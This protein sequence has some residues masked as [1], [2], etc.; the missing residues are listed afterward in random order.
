MTTLL[1]LAVS[2]VVLSTADVRPLGEILVEALIPDQLQRR[3]N[4][5]ERTAAAGA[6]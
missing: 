6:V 3:S 1:L 2:E 4:F 5:N